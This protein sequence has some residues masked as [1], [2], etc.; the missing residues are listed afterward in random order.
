MTVCKVHGARK[1]ETILRGKD[2]PRYKHG[3]ATQKARAEYSYKMQ[4][5]RVLEDL[6]FKYGIMVGSRTA[7][8]KP[9]PGN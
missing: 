7:G 4:E 8:R 1:R 5:L 3:K 2:H 9:K 6:G